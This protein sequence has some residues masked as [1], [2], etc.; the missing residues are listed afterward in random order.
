MLGHIPVL[1]GLRAAGTPV[2]PHDTLK[3]KGMEPVPADR[4]S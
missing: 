3:L 2:V 4:V 1:A